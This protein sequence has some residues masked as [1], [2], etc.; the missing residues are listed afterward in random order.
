MPACWIVHIFGDGCWFERLDSLLRTVANSVSQG[1]AWVT[2]VN[3]VKERFGVLMV[4]FEVQNDPLLTGL[5]NF[6]HEHA[7]P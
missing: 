2:K 7:D 4:Q 3:Q 5:R 6:A 1:R